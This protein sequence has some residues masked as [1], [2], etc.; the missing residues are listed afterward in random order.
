MNPP[1]SRKF[2]T[3]LIPLAGLL[4]LSS[5]AGPEP[6]RY[7]Y[8]PGK[9]AVIQNGYA[10]AP[11]SAPDRVKEAIAA[12]NRIAG[13]PYRYGGG[14]RSFNDSGYDCSGSASFVLH[15][16]GLL[17]SPM[18]SSG[19]RR[20]GESGPGKWISIYA[21]REHTFLVVAGLRFDTGYGPTRGA[22]PRWTDRDRTTTASVVRHP[23]GL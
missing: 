1:F 2:F 11:S 7:R 21:R 4:L 14:H 16:A 17:N 3:F 12:G 8:V 13:A 9:T 19:C 20:Y 18:P 5:C 22:G 15:A 10:I 6:Y 23:R